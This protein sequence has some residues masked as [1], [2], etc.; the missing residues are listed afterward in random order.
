M[1]FCVCDGE[2]HPELHHKIINAIK[3]STKEIKLTLKR[4][5]GI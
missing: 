4:T 2:G 3:I 5:F 1:K